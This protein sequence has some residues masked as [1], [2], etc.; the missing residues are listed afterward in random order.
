MS[1]VLTPAYGPSLYRC[2]FTLKSANMNSTSDQ[3]F[4]MLGNIT[5][6][7]LVNIFVTNAS[8][9]L[10]TAVGGIWTGAGQTGNNLVGAGQ[11]YS[12]LTS[13]TKLLIP[14]LASGAT[15]N[16][17]SVAPILH[18]VTPQGSSSTADFYAFG[19][20]LS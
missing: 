4:A 20:D 8:I 19:M 7:I 5:S 13:A 11:A 18:L 1:N 2:L 9:S 17:Q 10:T 12:S 16:L 14:S 15:T 3:G 6:Y